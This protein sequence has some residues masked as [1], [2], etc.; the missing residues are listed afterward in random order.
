MTAEIHHDIDSR[1]FNQILNKLV[2]L[3]RAN[4]KAGKRTFVYFQYG[5]HGFVDDDGFTQALCNIEVTD[6]EEYD[7]QLYPI[8]KQLRTLAE[9][10]DVYILAVLDC[11][12]E[13]IEKREIP[14][15]GGN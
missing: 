10:P 9:Y 4:A 3:I 8:E 1:Q 2:K 12:R 13:R 5:G 15:R 11:C 6:D 7:R 14:T